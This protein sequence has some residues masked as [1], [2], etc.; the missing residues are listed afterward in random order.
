M[1]EIFYRIIMKTKAGR[2]LYLKCTNI[3]SNGIIKCEWDFS[4]EDVIWF[5]TDTQ[6]EKFCAMYF[7]N[8]KDYEI[9]EFKYYI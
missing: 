4:S 6:A 2:K 9:E 3:F 8:F 5:E 1:L 7:K